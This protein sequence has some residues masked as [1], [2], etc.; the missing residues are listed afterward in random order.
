M[1]PLPSP[2]YTV[3]HVNC[4]NSL[5][6]LQAAD[7]LAPSLCLTSS[8][9]DLFKQKFSPVLSLPK[10]LQRLPITLEKLSEQS[11]TS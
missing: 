9:D 2:C 10:T 4:H 6:T 11:K 3:S 8:Q 7:I 5:L 1:L